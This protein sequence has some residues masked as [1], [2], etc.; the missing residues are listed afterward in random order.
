M[1]AIRFEFCSF[2][3]DLGRE[4]EKTKPNETEFRTK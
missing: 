1:D 4:G 2:A 3:R